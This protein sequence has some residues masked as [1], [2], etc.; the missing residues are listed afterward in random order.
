MVVLLV[1]YMR[2]RIQALRAGSF[3]YFLR[4]RR[5]VNVVVNVVM[6]LFFSLLN[7]LEMLDGIVEMMV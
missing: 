6:R 3:L 5:S 7:I 1:T 2:T 4:T